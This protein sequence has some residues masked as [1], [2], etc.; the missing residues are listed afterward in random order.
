[1]CGLPLM[2]WRG[3]VE[4]H[5]AKQSAVSVHVTETVGEIM[6]FMST[7][8]KEPLSARLIKVNQ[9]AAFNL[10]RVTVVLFNS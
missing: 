2:I 9:G 4:G 5:A 8:K 7:H 10:R 3:T 1:V 6:V